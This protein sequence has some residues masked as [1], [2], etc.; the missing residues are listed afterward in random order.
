LT[1]AVIR[2]GS[3]I[4]CAE[5]ISQAEDFTPG[6]ENGRSNREGVVA[7]LRET[8]VSTHPIRRRTGS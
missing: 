4:A 2:L 1:A 7:V 5:A 6:S 3:S 8:S